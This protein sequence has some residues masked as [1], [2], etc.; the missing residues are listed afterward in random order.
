MSVI[1]VSRGLC[2][3]F[4]CQKWMRITLKPDGANGTSKFMEIGGRVHFFFVSV[5]NNSISADSCVSFMPAIRLILFVKQKNRW[6]N[7]MRGKEGIKRIHILPNNCVLG[8]LVLGFAFQANQLHTRCIQRS[9][10]FHLNLLAQQRWLEVRF[11]YHLPMKK[12][13]FNANFYRFLFSSR[14]QFFCRFHHG[15][16]CYLNFH[17]CSANL[18]H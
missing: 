14:M 7:W 17:L 9:W 2:L 15:S 8:R 1:S 13:V 10:N 3:F 4:Y 16:T 5:S 12:N 6:A 11:E 18:S